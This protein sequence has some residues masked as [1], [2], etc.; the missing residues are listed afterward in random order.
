MNQY[1]IELF[2][3][4]IS[5]IVLGIT[6]IP[7]IGLAIIGLDYFK[8]SD[9][10]SILGAALFINLFPITGPSVWE[11]Y[12]SGKMDFTMAWIL[13]TTITLG[14]YLGSRYVVKGKNQMS[15]KS[16]KYFTAYFSFISGI[17]FLLSAYYEK[18]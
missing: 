4:L 7:G 8:V 14:S 12:K 3:G 9:Y 6:G 2:F 1:I 18:D 15:V 10:K 5:G 17:L 16:I 11:F 13:L